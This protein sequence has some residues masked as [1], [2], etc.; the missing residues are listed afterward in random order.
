MEGLLLKKGNQVRIFTA[1]RDVV[2]MENGVPVV[3]GQWRCATVPDGGKQLNAFS[4][5]FDGADADPVPIR[6]SFNERNQLVGVIPAAANG[7]ADSPAFAFAGMI[8]VD[9]NRDIAYELLDTDGQPTGID[10]IVLGQLSFNEQDNAL[11]IRFEG[12]GSPAT[13]IGDSGL[14]S[15]STGM[16]AFD[17]FKG[18]DFLR[19]Q[20]STINELPSGDIII[21]PADI[22]W[23]GNWD[24]QEN[25]L[26]FAA[27][28]KT[29]TGRRPSISCWPARPKRWPVAWPISQDLTGASWR[30]R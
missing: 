6:W 7:G 21:S 25:R 26:V 28:L 20:A 19:F 27:E 22:Q 10:I 16:Y 30:S 12:G 24:L 11:E 14:G 3:H 17:D 15:L 13:V 5:T 9:D 1:T 29:T 2:V 8:K 4:Y 23:V 18:S